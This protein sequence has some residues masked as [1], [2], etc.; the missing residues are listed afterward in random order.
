[1]KGALDCPVVL[2]IHL[3]VRSDIVTTISRERLEQ[4]W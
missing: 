1:V 3:F 2:F 4:F